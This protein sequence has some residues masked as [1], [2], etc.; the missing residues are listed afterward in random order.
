MKSD[1]GTLGNL[2]GIWFEKLNWCW[3]QVKNVE[4]LEGAQCV[5]Y[6]H[7]EVEVELGSQEECGIKIYTSSSLPHGVC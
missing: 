3:L 7:V 5:R 1:R 6:A 2:I 4:V